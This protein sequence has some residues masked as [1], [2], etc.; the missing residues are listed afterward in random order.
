M[1][2]TY[3]FMEKQ[4]KNKVINNGYSFQELDSSNFLIETNSEIYFLTLDKNIDSKKII[5]KCKKMTKQLSKL[6]I[7][8]IFILINNENYVLKNLKNGNMI[9]NFF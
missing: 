8:F 4:I 7:P 9:V 5:D 3:S 6:I 1:V 2:D